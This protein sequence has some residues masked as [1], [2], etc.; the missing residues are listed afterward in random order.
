MNIAQRIQR[1]RKESG[2]SQEQLAN[3]IGVS[4]QAVS[5]WESEQSVPDLDK[6]IALSEYFNVTTDYILKGKNSKTESDKNATA[7][8]ILYIASVFF[9]IIGLL[10]AC[11]AWFEEQLA[12]DIAGGMII[13]AVGVAAYFVGAA[14]S[15]EKAS[16]AIKILNTA[17]ALF[18]PVSLLAGVFCG[19]TV[20]PYPIGILHVVLFVII[21]A[22]VT[23]VFFKIIK[24]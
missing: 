5:K 23:S 19:F 13:Q 17:A 18:M 21:Y 3:E 15:K 22:A 4:R 1:L 8:K 7:S 9:I 16:R 20:S 10:S 11:G 12:E 6:I 14:I 2:L 24:K